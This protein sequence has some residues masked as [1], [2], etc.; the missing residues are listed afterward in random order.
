MLVTIGGGQKFL[1]LDNAVARSRELPPKQV[2]TSDP[3]FLF[4]EESK[5]PLFAGALHPRT[6]PS[7][8]MT[9]EIPG[10]SVRR[11]TGWQRDCARLGVLDSER[12]RRPSWSARS[13]TRAALGPWPDVRSLRVAAAVSIVPSEVI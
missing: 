10:V 12:A 4:A 13:A 2:D 9:K 3:T 1:T 6:L 7:R 8:F 11:R 5:Y